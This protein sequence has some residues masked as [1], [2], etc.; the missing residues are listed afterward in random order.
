MPSRR[1]SSRMLSDRL[2]RESGT[3][4]GSTEATGTQLAEQYY[5]FALRVR[6]QNVTVGLQVG[7]HSDIDVVARSYSEA[8]EL[9]KDLLP[10]ASY[11]EMH[12]P[13]LRYVGPYARV[14]TAT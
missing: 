13:E 2:Q 4:S 9:M 1:I 3:P 10:P 5:T 11:P 12:I 7:A 6:T 14:V 8:T